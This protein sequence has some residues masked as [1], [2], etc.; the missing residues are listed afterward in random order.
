[1][2]MEMYTNIS[3][4]TDNMIINFL[5]GTI[6][7]E[8]KVAFENWLASSKENKAEFKKIYSIWKAASIQQQ[9]HTAIQHAFE[10][11]HVHT[12]TNQSLRFS[13]T[14]SHKFPSRLFIASRK[15]A[16][17]LIGII[18]LSAPALYFLSSNVSKQD[19]SLAKNVISVPLG[20]KS[21]IVLPDGTEVWL[22]AGSK[23]TYDMSYGR[24]TRE[25]NLIGEG[26]F[27]VTRQ[28]KKP[29]IVHTVKANIKALGTEF[30]VKAYPDES[31]IETIL[32]K[33]SVAVNQINVEKERN[34][35]SK[36]PSLILKPGQK[37]RIY[38]VKDALEPKVDVPKIITPK[39]AITEKI[40]SVDNRI[41]LENT[42][43]LIETSW[44]DERW[45]IKGESMDV[46]A[47][48]LARHFNVSIIL[49]NENLLKYKFSGTIQNE[50]LEQVFNIMALTIPINF[51]I[52]KGKVT[53]SFNNRFEERYKA[54]YK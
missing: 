14:L 47:V 20:S 9:D 44:K 28:E 1:M 45:I 16:A 51:T 17:I 46:L 21:K 54:A 7:P 15:W 18:L 52:D 39:K 31:Y 49:S 13:D 42:N 30:N 19:K 43:V 4:T 25:V 6:T 48:L 8:E 40:I 37:A 23:L 36:E 11:V 10:K 34:I 33:G 26:Y 32:V 2:E 22:N 53:I 5:R 27:K 41:M 24:K 38:K 12:F 29:F 3:E 50:T 35:I